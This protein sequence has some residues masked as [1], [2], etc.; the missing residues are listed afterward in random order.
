[1]NQV[2]VKIE[3]VSPLLM[4]RYIPEADPGTRKTNPPKGTPFQ[5]AELK[6]YKD[7]KGKPCIPGPNIYSGIIEAGHFQKF[8]KSKMTTAKASCISSGVFV[9]DEYCLVTPTNWCV[10]ERSIVNPATGGRRLCYRP[11][12]DEWSLRFTVEYDP[13]MSFTD[14]IVRHLVEDMGA[15]LGLGDFRPQ[16]KGPF[17]RFKVTEFFTG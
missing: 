15:R 3:G 12:F 8:G 13:E 9:L 10:D 11:R 14:E 1:M 4:N 17:G 6:V 7:P 16:R 5:Q 2:K